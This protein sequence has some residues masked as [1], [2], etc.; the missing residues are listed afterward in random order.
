[1]FY[2]KKL[3]KIKQLKHCF[4]S[5][6]KGLSK[7]IYKRLNCGRGSKDKKNNIIKNLSYMAKKMGGKRKNII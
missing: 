7:G 3:R 5:R 1:M 6:K 4:F 2:S